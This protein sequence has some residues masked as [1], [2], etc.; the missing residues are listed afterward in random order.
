M[1]PPSPKLSFISSKDNMIITNLPVNINN[2]SK[3][4]IKNIQYLYNNTINEI[5]FS[6]LACPYCH[7]CCW[8]YHAC[9][10][11]SFIFSGRLYKIIISR[12]YC[13]HCHKTH[14]ILPDFL[15]PYAV[16]SSNDIIE[17][18]INRDTSSLDDSLLSY[19]SDKLKDF[20]HPSHLLLCLVSIRSNSCI[21]MF[22]HDF[23]VFSSAFS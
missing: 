2:L 21:Y 3:L 15:V 7:H 9:Y 10:C 16:Y 1:K 8:K 17:A 19:W 22:S 20:T 18:F 4:S 6:S 11:R 23:F 5:Q 13:H 14:S 12:V